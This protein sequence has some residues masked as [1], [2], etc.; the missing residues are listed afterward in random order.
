MARSIHSEAQQPVYRFQK[1]LLCSPGLEMCPAA[2]GTACGR[3]SAVALERAATG[4]APIV[5]TPRDLP[6]KLHWDRRAFERCPEWCAA[7]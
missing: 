5:R 7:V 6:L 1:D 4:L 3:S 2:A